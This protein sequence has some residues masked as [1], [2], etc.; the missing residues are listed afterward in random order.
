M[1]LLVMNLYYHFLKN[2]AVLKSYL[3]LKLLED[4]REFLYRSNIRKR[5]CHVRVSISPENKKGIPHN[6]DIFLSKL[7]MGLT[8]KREIAQTFFTRFCLATILLCKMLLYINA[9][10]VNGIYIYVN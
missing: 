8:V 4:T 3:V 5:K 1:K 10:H 9:L 2:L 7:R 6:T